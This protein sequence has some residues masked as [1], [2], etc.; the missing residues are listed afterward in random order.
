MRDGRGNPAPGLGVLCVGVVAA[1][2]VHLP[3]QPVPVAGLG[4]GQADAKIGGDL[5]DLPTVRSSCR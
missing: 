4:L 5:V 3:G 2:L 1:A